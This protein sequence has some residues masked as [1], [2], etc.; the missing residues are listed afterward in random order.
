MIYWQERQPSPWKSA[1]ART[2]G[3]LGIGA[4]QPSNWVDLWV[5]L[6][7]HFFFFLLFFFAKKQHF[8]EGVV[9]L[10]EIDKPTRVL[11]VMTTS[12]LS[13]EEAPLWPVVKSE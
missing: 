5:F 7:V 9:E 2:S 6:C 3:D 4:A 13:R 10:K 8:R 12:H 11:N 1:K